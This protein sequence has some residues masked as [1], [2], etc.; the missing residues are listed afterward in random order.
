MPRKSAPTSGSSAWRSSCSR[1]GWSWSI[2]RA[3][4]SRPIAST[5]RTSFSRSSSSGR[6]WAL[7]LHVG[8]R[9]RSTTGSRPLVMPA[10]GRSPSCC[11]C[12]CSC[13]RSASR[14]TAR[15]AGSGWGPVSSSR[16]SSP[17][18]PG[19]LPRGVPRA[20]AKP[21]GDFWRGL[22]PPLAVAGSVAGWSCCAA[23]SRQRR[24]RHRQ[25]RALLFFGAAAR[26]RHLG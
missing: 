17:S 16:P 15:A 13:R 3:R 11:W 26:A 5:I 21:I 8:R 25:L 9:W 18:W 10:P 24:W 2:R 6:C 14:S 23:R 19:R 7:G 4:S 12:S 22:V 20:A 1:L